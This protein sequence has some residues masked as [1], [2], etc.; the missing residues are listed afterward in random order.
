ME[1]PRNKY[2]GLRINSEVKTPLVL[3][4]ALSANQ[5]IE[6]PYY[7]PATVLIGIDEPEQKLIFSSYWLGNN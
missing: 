2:L 5:P 3:F 4:L 1:F 7:Y 6:P